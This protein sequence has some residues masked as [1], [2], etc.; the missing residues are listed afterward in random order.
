VKSDADLVQR[1]Q[2]GD[3]E[4]FGR[5]IERYERT[6]VAVALAKLRDIH[7][8]EDVAQTTALRAFERLHTLRQA[9]RFGPWLMQIARSQAIDVLR[10]RRVAAVAG[11]GESN[12]DPAAEP[13]GLPW[14]ES[15]HLLSL[16]ARL[17]DDERVLIGQRY[18]DG[19]SMADI[20]AGLGR[21]VG[22]V[23][24]QLSRAV[25]RLRKWWN[26]EDEQ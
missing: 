18:F 25:A 12:D 5:L 2:G 9:D 17:N 15:D 4:A 16:V 26:E 7:A 20:A 10:S 3:V 19:H 11:A 14:I 1:V 8:A 6:L 24:K 22:S 13:D 23:T 21:P